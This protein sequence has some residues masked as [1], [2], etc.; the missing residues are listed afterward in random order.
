VGSEQ[1]EWGEDEG[2]ADECGEIGKR[3]RETQGAAVALE[4]G[5][6]DAD[7][8]FPRAASRSERKQ[9][10]R[11]AGRTVRGRRRASRTKR[12]GMTR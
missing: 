2:E 8:E 4:D 5:E 1:N 6:G 12:R 11:T 10:K 7:A 3:W 9:T